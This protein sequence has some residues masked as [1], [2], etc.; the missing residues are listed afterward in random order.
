MLLVNNMHPC[1][2]LHS[3]IMLIPIIT[4]IALKWKL[5]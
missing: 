2:Q 3:F 1:K 4:F 5:F